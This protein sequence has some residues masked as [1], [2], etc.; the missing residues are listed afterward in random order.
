MH[1]AIVHIHASA[2]H[3]DAFL[4][5][6][7]ANQAASCREPGN[8]RFDVLQAPDDPTR[9]LLYEAYVDAAAAAAHKETAHYLAWRET[10]ADWFV[11]PRVGVPWTP[12]A[13]GPLPVAPADARR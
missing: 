7:L 8:L 12:L 11:E 1:V 9:L 5:A 3:L 4:A 6:T 13:V 10:V 2:E